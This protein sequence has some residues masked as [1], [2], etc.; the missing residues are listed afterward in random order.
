LAHTEGLVLPAVCVKTL[1]IRNPRLCEAVPARQGTRLPL[2]P[3]GYAGDASSIL[4]A[5]SPRLRHGCKTRYGWVAHP[6]PTGTCTLPE[7]P[8]F[9]GAITLG[10]SRACQ[11]QRGTSE[12]WQ[13][14]AAG[15]GSAVGGGPLSGPSRAAAP[16]YGI[17]SSAKTRSVGGNVIPSA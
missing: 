17:T 8:S 6:Y 16:C 4:C 11:P 2:R 9:L 10:L 1:G 3:P 14:S 12:G 7:T 5:V 13:V 15:R